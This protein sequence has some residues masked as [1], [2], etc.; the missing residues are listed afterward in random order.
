MKDQETKR[1]I[2]ANDVIFGTPWPA[3]PTGNTRQIEIKNLFS[4][5]TTGVVP[6]TDALDGNQLSNV[7]FNMKLECR[8]DWGQVA[9]AI[10]GGTT[11]VIFRFYVIA[12][13]DDFVSAATFTPMALPVEGL[14]FQ[15]T[16]PS[17]A[18]LE[19]QNVTMIQMKT[20]RMQPPSVPAGATGY[21]FRFTSKT[22]TLKQF[23][24]GRK[25]FQIVNPT[26]GPGSGSI[27]P[28]LKGHQYYVVALAGYDSIGNTVASVQTGFQVI[29]D[30]YMYYKDG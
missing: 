11:A 10:G 3:A 8:V 15:Q 4:Q 17:R 14:V 2:V 24:R 25:E 21:N 20:V 28:V 19:G 26:T 7:Q 12:T 9:A 23:F 5:V 29:A 16:E 18:T 30:T 6:V 27:A 1:I 13:A 22:V